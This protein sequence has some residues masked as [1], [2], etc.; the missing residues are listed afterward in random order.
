MSTQTVERISPADYLTQERQ[1]EFKSEYINR[2]VHP[3]AGASII[4]QIITGNIFFLLK[5]ALRKLD[6]FIFLSDMRVRSDQSYMYPDVGIAKGKGEYDDSRAD[7]LINPLLIVEVLSSSTKEYD[8][9]IKFEAYRKLSSLREYLLVAQD[10]PHVELF[11][12]NDAGRWE[13]FET[14]GLESSIELTSIGCTLQLNEVY[15]D[16]EF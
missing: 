5:L 4:H 10:R 9:G 12:L 2:E 7:V 1:A 8:R 11:R 15:E 6:Y 14:T 13:L 3:M 16:I